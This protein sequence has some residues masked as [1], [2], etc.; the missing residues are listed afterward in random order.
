MK[1]SG[2]QSIRS[3]ILVVLLAGILVLCVGVIF[4]VVNITES[5]LNSYFRSQLDIKFNGFESDLEARQNRLQN[6]LG[7]FVGDK[8]LNRKLEINNLNDL[9]EYISLEK[10]AASISGIYLTS[11]DGTILCSTEGT[12]TR[13]DLLRDN[14]TVKAALKN[15]HA[16]G[17]SVASKNV[18][19][20]AVRTLDTE[21]SPDK[22]SFCVFEECLTTDDICDYYH[23][24]LDCAFTIF[25]DDVRIATSIKDKNGN[26]IIGT[27]LNNQ[28]IY[29]TV[30]TEQKKYYGNNII[31][32]EKYMTIYA[33]AELDH[34]EKKAIFFIGQ[35]G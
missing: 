31:Q 32:G 24:M 5:Q 6:Q 3:K 26:R 28:A 12:G 22:P 20:I 4:T 33:R 16:E 29:K 30:Y 1:K 8:E 23:N 15:G 25:I 11:S 14:D 7:K 19:I 9:N 21:H 27:A 34:P 35:I 13:R 17:V 10:A 18:S 2:T